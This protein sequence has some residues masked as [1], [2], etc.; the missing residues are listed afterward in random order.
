MTPRPNWRD[1]PVV[2]LLDCEVALMT[3]QEA[4]WCTPLLAERRQLLTPHST[5][6]R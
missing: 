3:E 5:E 1:L 4:K 2:E 6:E